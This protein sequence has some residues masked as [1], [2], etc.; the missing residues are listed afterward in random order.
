MDCS[1]AL[2]F[3]VPI[4]SCSAHLHALPAVRFVLKLLCLLSVLQIFVFAPVRFLLKDHR[5]D[6]Q[7]LRS[8]NLQDSDTLGTTRVAVPCEVL[9]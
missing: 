6:S 9:W 8:M 7:V 4:Y 3:A 5:I 1:D 2:S